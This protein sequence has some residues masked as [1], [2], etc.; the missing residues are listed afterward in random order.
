MNPSLPAS[1]ARRDTRRI[2]LVLPPPPCST[3]S[4]GMPSATEVPSGVWTMYMR[5]NPWKRIATD[6]GDFCQMTYHPA[7][8]FVRP[9]RCD[10]S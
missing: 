5:L 3:I 9:L 10:N 4:M 8:L 6:S 1:S 2:A 7:C